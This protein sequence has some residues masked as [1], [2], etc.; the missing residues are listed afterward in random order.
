[1]LLLA[2]GILAIVHS[3]F[4]PLRPEQILLKSVR[5]FCV[6]CSRVLSEFQE[7]EPANRTRKRRVRKRVFESLIQPVP[8]K[9]QAAQKNLNYNL[10]PDNSPEKVQTLIDALQ[11]IAYRLQSLEITQ[12]RLTQHVSGLPDSF[13][14]VGSQ[15]QTFLQGAFQ[16]WQRFE[17]SEEL[18]QRQNEL[19]QLSD[20]LEQQL[21]QMAVDPDQKQF[22]DQTQTDLYTT[23]GSL[24]SLIEAMENMETV[25]SQ[26]NWRQWAIVRF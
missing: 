20:E 19:A 8:Q 17:S 11:N 7:E 12:N 4:S 6:G 9:I 22:N 3:L 14:P 16:S 15:I 21:D 5:Q 1:M 18:A 2:L 24:R 10:F 23:I 26:I 13:K 25:I